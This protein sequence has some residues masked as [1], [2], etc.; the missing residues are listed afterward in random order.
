[1]RHDVPCAIVPRSRA[2]YIEVIIKEKVSF[3]ITLSDRI[4]TETMEIRDQEKAKKVVLTG[5]MIG[6]GIGM[7]VSFYYAL[8][9]VSK[10]PRFWPFAFGFVALAMISFSIAGVFVGL[11]ISS[12]QRKTD[13]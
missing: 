4:W 12:F 13:E 3:A 6:A 9:V 2:G 5:M 11:F 1:M 10:W 8:P 7:L